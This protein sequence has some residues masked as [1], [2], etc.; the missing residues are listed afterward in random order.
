MAT[1]RERRGTSGTDFSGVR[2]SMLSMFGEGGH[3]F[4]YGERETTSFTVK[5]E[6]T[7]RYRG[8]L[9]DALNSGADNDRLDGGSGGD[10][11]YGISGTDPLNAGDGHDRLWGEDDDDTLN[12]GIGN[13]TLYG[14]WYGEAGRDYLDG[15]A[16]ADSLWGGDDHNTLKGGAGTDKLYGK[17]GDDRLDSRAGADTLTGGIRADTF[18]FG[19]EKD[20]VKDSPIWL[21]F[22]DLTPELRAT[23][24]RSQPSLHIDR[25]VS[26]H[27]DVSLCPMESVAPPPRY[28]SHIPSSLS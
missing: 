16:R 19:K 10:V 14:G 5:M 28:R 9:D 2:S 11:L 7:F 15:G 1:N 12:G 24:S 27:G 3:D 18:I 17:A 4:L 23:Q 20:R 8:I 22:F 13:D 26:A 6:T 25:L 21:N